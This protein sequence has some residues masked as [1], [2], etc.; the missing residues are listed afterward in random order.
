LVLARWRYNLPASW[1]GSTFWVRLARRASGTVHIAGA[2]D[3]GSGSVGTGHYVA[4]SVTGDV[5]VSA[6]SV[7]ASVIAAAI[8][9]PVSDHALAV[10]VVAV[11]AVRVVAVAIPAV[12]IGAIAIPPW[13]IEP[14]KA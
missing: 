9:Y 10:I 8:R 12:V 4:A 11:I 7:R 6:S 3:R 2:G 14:A 1:L 5:G 13:V